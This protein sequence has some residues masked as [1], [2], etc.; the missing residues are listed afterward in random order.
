MKNEANT[1]VTQDVCKDD[2]DNM[3]KSDLCEV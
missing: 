3:Q 1:S 2:I